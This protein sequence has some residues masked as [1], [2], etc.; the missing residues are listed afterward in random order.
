M[1]RTT[2]YPHRRSKTVLRYET[3][4]IY[5]KL[6]GDTHVLRPGTDYEGPV[7]SMMVAPV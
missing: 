5:V 6:C 3:Q 7:F 2:L 1:C 4:R